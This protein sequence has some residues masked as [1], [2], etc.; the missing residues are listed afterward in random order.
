MKKVL[1]ILGAA[2]M[3]LSCVGCGKEEI[4]NEEQTSSI[5]EQTIDESNDFT[6]ELSSNID[7]LYTDVFKEIFGD[8]FD[9]GKAIVDDETVTYEGRTVS[10]EYIEEVVY[11][12]MTNSL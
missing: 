7:E 5:Y 10:F 1:V 3:M 8:D 4:K 2:F 6:E 9:A 12:S 11:N